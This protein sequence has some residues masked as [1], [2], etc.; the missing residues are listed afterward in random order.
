MR[1]TALCVYEYRIMLYVYVVQVY[2]CL[3]KGGGVE[4]M[5]FRAGWRSPNCSSA[6]K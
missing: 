3:H 5:L 1:S 2:G 6:P 4:E